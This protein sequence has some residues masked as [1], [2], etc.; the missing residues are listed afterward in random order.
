MLSAL[1]MVDP[2]KQLPVASRP[3]MLALGAD[4]VARGKLFDDLNVRGQPRPCKDPL[5]QVMTQMAVLRHPS[6][7]CR[8]EGIDVIDALAGERAFA[9]QI[10]IDVRHRC[11]IGIHAAGA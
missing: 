11:R 1:L 4:V 9:K 8:S 5:E 7:Q 10:L 6:C 2:G 3:A